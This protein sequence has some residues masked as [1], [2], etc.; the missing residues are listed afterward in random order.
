MEQHKV[1]GLEQGLVR[2]HAPTPAWVELYIKE[3]ALVRTAL[4]KWLVGLEH[5]GS[6]SIPNIKAKPILD[7]MV[8]INRLAD[9]L[10]CKE[11]LEALGYSHAS[12]IDIENDIVYTKGGAAWTHLLHVVEFGSRQWLCNL[13]FRDRLRNEPELAQEYEHLKEHLSQ[14]FSNNRSAYTKA[15]ADFI[16]SVVSQ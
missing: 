15:K 6:T 13:R 5:I 2:L 14:Q 7:M 10:A 9:G 4:A 8:G 12:Q 11:A 16:Q 3:S 1:L